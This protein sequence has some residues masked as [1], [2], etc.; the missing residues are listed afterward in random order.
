MHRSR[1]RLAGPAGRRHRRWV[2]PFDLPGALRRIRRTADLSQRELAAR[3]GVSKSAVAA[4]ESM[5][6]GLDVRVLA[7]SAELAG[8]R[9]ALLDEHGGEV[10]P[11]AA[12]TVRDLSGRRFPAHLDTGRSDEKRW[13]YEPRPDRPETWFTF[14]RDRGGRDALRRRLGTPEDHHPLRPG[15]SPAE[16]KAARRRDQ[17]R[18]REEKRERAFLAGEFARIHLGFHCTCPAACDE[19]DDRSGKPVHAPECVCDCDVA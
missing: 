17:L 11:M 18:R 6:G 9:L 5:A 10:R 1:E 15:D 13:L 4:A 2:A 16:R 3:I 14:A 7:R 19:L 8:L 12:D